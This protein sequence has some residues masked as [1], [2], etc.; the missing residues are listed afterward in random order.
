MLQNRIELFAVELEEQKVRVMRLLLLAAVTVLLG[1]TA[2]LVLTAAIVALAGET[3]WKIV[4]AGFAIFYLLA[5][6]VAALFLRRELRSAPPAFQDTVA[7]LGKD[8]EWLSGG[9]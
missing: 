3:A 9:N 1:N 6:I 8:H 5:A 4:L 2:V 7:E